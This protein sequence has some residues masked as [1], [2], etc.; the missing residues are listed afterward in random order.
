MIY[1][2]QHDKSIKLFLKY[3]NIII[4]NVFLKEQ[5]TEKYTLFNMLLKYFTL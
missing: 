5:D 2:N 3:K 4:N 1:F